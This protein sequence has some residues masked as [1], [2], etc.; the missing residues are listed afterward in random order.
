MPFHQEAIVRETDPPRSSPHNT[1][2]FRVGRSGE[3]GIIGFEALRKLAGWMAARELNS[4][5]GSDSC[6]DRRIEPSCPPAPAKGHDAAARTA[7][8]S[9]AGHGGATGCPEDPVADCSS[10]HD[11]KGSNATRSVTSDNTSRRARDTSPRH[12]SPKRRKQGE[13]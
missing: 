4:V 6:N 8:G 10:A 1:T 5:K 2:E 3:I 13:C 7:L 9:G 11:S 12:E